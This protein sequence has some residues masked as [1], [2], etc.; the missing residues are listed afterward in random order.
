MRKR[1]REKHSSVLAVNSEGR[2]V[3]LQI[4]KARWPEWLKGAYQ[5]LATALIT[6]FQ[7]HTGEVLLDQQRQGIEGNSG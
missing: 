5:A 6:R 1:R 2:I 4:E 3:E 7:V